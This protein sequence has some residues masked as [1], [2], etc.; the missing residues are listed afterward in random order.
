M[1]KVFVKLSSIL[2]VLVMV[3]AVIL[4][5]NAAFKAVPVS[6]SVIRT[7]TTLKC[8]ATGYCVESSTGHYGNCTV[9]A[10]TKGQTTKTAVKTGGTASITTAYTAE[11]TMNATNTVSCKVAPANGTAAT[12]SYTV[13]K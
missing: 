1:K 9:T 11:V 13:Y 4:P 8:N 12:A 7:S 5:V 6:N 3:F 10:T 2:L